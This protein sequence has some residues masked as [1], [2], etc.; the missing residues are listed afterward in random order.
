MT[1]AWSRVKLVAPLAQYRERFAEVDDIEH[2]T[3]ADDRWETAHNYTPSSNDM[4]RL[5]AR[6]DLK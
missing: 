3:I 1:T 5:E 4:D 6:I 2:P